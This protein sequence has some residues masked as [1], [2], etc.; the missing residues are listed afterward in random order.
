ML[1]D[2]VPQVREQYES[3]P[4]PPRAP[5]AEKHRLVRTYPGFIDKINHYC[6][7]GN[8]LFP[9]EFRALMAGD[10]TGD[11][12][13]FIAEQLRDRGCEITYIDISR[14]SM[15]IA[16]QRADVRGLKNIRFI[17]AS[18]NDIPKLELGQFDYISCSG[19]LHHLED[20]SVG[21]RAL[22]SVLKA[23]G[24][25]DI[26]VYAPYGRAGIYTM[27]TL[28]KFINEGVQ[29]MHQKLDNCKR[30]LPLLPSTNLFR[31]LENPRSDHITTGDAGI[32][33]L[34]LHSVD[35]AYSVSELHD[36]VESCGLRIRHFLRTE[37]SYCPASYLTDKNLLSR[38]QSLPQK[39]QQ[40]VAELLA[41][42]MGKHTF[43]AS[44]KP[45]R[46][47]EIANE[48]NIPLIASFSQLTGP[49]FSAALA[50]KPGETVTFEWPAPRFVIELPRT[51]HAEMI[52]R[53]VDG[54][55]SIRSI[56]ENVRNECNQKGLPVPAIG[57]LRDEFT[58]IFSA[59]NSVEAMLLRGPATSPVA[60][61]RTVEQQMLRTG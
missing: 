14:A 34:L 2:Y 54:H 53:H 50:N 37:S 51:A 18:I 30:L 38:I 41:G 17:H 56:Y 57:V 58:N 33:D 39:K 28:M 20:P 44:A 8:Q 13:I 15:E 49:D 32:Y 24:A 19:V 5:S 45:V 21:L 25:L 4:Y 46:F 10:G 26:M 16:R 35:R 42:N 52:F 48:E 3:L 12:T 11:S 22:V 47:P 9:G 40:A 60:S 36:W 7:E 6:F 59:L 43:Y 29:D 27:Q 23:E 1:G 31:R 61:L 55:N